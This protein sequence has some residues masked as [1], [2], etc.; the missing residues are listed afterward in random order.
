M[1]SG[2]CGLLVSRIHALFERRNAQNSNL[3]KVKMHPM[4]Y[5]FS[6]RIN[7]TYHI[8]AWIKLKANLLF[9][10]PDYASG[11]CIRA[12]SCPSAD[13]FNTGGGGG[14]GGEE[15]A[16]CSFASQW[17]RTL[18]SH[19]SLPL[20][21]LDQWAFRAFLGRDCCFIHFPPVAH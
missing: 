11:T 17:S 19:P 1:P 10:L 9:R 14:G 21:S 16:S 4:V 20:P 13:L 15:A 5:N 12:P 8:L 2:N 18:P 3:L 6:S 7:N